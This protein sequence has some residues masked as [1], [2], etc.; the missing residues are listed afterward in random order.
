MC[1]SHPGSK[2]IS[3]MKEVEMSVFFSLNQ[4]GMMLSFGGPGAGAARG[5]GVGMAEPSVSDADAPG[6]PCPRLFGA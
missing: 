1:Y 6:W 3:A 5:I 4:K 2:S